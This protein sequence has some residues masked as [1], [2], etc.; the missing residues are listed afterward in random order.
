MAEEKEKKGK[1]KTGIDFGIGLGGIFEGIGNLIESISKIAEE[2][3]GVISKAG[4]IKGLGDKVKGIYGFTIR[5]LAGGESKV[6]PFGNIKKTPKGPV[7]EEEREPIVDVFDEKDHILVIAEL[8]G[9]E[10]ADIKTEIKDDILNISAEKGERKY[11]KEVLL[12]SKVEA[13]PISS[14]YKNGILEIKLTKLGK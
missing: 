13:E 11:K 7:V 8:P 4:E 6:E 5:T 9:I 10:E 14:T 12:P 3:K 1:K 2:G